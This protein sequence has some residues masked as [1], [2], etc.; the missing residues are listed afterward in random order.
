MPTPS[1]KARGKKPNRSSAESTRKRAGKAKLAA[2]NKKRKPKKNMK[3]TA[4]R[5]PAED[6]PGWNAAIH[7]NK[8]EG[9]GRTVRGTP[10]EGIKAK[11]YPRIKAD[12]K[13]KSGGRK[14]RPKR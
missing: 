9:R 13:R 5:K 14:R 10:F 6:D 1:K 12:A 3:F 11:S 4:F 7:G 8:I 2:A